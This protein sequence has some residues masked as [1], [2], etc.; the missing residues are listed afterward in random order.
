[1]KTCRS[2]ACH[3]CHARAWQAWARPQATLE[4]M[5]SEEGD[6]TN[7]E[8]PV[9]EPE[10]SEEEPF[11][12]EE[13]RCD[14]EVVPARTPYIREAD[15]GCSQGRQFEDLDHDV[16]FHDVESTTTESDLD[17]FHPEE[18]CMETP[19]TSVASA[20]ASLSSPDASIQGGESIC[21]DCKVVPGPE[22]LSALPFDIPVDPV[23][24]TA[25]D[26]MDGQG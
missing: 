14:V 15:L 21:P 23:E 26:C 25:L 24:W 4:D 7:V 6:F 19:T 20:S 5:E 17:A 9:E 13:P 8:L 3:A 2:S 1:M 18:H 22:A 16:D 11:D 10:E 12:S